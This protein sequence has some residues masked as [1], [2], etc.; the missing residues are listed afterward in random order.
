M[1]S[2]RARV[3][4]RKGRV[5][6]RMRGGV[7]EMTIP[8]LSDE[9]VLARENIAITLYKNLDIFKTN[10]NIV[11]YADSMDN[12]NV[13]VYGTLQKTGESGLQ[14]MGFYSKRWLQIYDATAVAAAVA[15]GAAPSAP[16]FAE[17][18]KYSGAGEEV[19]ATHNSLNSPAAAPTAAA[20][21]N[22]FV[23]V[24]SRSEKMTEPKVIFLD[25]IETV[26]VIDPEGSL[27]HADGTKY[28]GKRILVLTYKESC[29]RMSPNGKEVIKFTDNRDDEYVRKWFLDTPQKHYLL[30][31]NTEKKS[32]VDST[33]PNSITYSERWTKER[34]SKGCFINE[35]FKALR[36]HVR[37]PP[38]RP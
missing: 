35:W 11:P 22:V 27:A 2:G 6:R 10:L 1:R 28:R 12:P 19:T 36:L 37:L 38:I 24:Y 20:T 32:W 17:L 3:V 9:D 14:K 33:N 23:L 15:A 30:H 34:R 25:H 26:D 21:P 7:E 29:K 18:S 13:Y 16:D 4:T 5:R 8:S 31:S